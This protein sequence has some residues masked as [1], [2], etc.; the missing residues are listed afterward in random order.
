M[1]PVLGDRLYLCEKDFD[2]GT[3]VAG[4]SVK[5]EFVIRNLH[6][7]SVTVK[8]LRGCCGCTKGF[9]NKET[10]FR[11]LPFQRALV[12][13]SVDTEGKKGPVDE[14]LYI[15]TSDNPLGTSVHLKGDIR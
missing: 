2:F 10:P 14:I 3:V 8:S 1:F 13:A 7:W 12:N 11:L 5:H 4:T 6:P 15:V 9:V